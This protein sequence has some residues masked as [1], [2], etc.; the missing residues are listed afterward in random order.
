MVSWPQSVEWFETYRVDIADVNR[1]ILLD[2]DLD[3]SEI[4]TSGAKGSLDFSDDPTV[5]VGVVAL[6]FGMGLSIE[7]VL[8]KEERPTHLA[9]S[10]LDL[11]LQFF[12]DSHGF[13]IAASNESIWGDDSGQSHSSGSKDGEDGGET[14]YDWESG[15]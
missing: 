1:D 13:L 3:L 4:M 10:D 14:H 15:S 7:G 2:F 9:D 5:A 11:D 8:R 12:D 6:V